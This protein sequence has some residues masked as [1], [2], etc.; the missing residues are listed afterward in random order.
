MAAYYPPPAGYYAPPQYPYYPPP[1]PGAAQPLPPAVTHHL[2]Q[3]Y[4]PFPSYATPAYPQVASYDE[5]RTLFIA[6][7]PEDVKPRE[8]YNLF[9]EFPGYESSHLR[10]PTEKTQP[11]G[12]AVFMDQQ[13][14]LAALHTLNG[15]VFDLEKGS[16]LHIDLAKSNSRSKR[17]RTDDDRHG[18]EKRSKGSSAFSRGIPDPVMDTLMLMQ[19]LQQIREI[20]QLPH[21]RHYLWLI[22]VQPVQSK[23]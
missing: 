4:Q 13:S 9:R 12:F 6:G 14:A 17:S 1:P 19:L 11:F 7:L 5:V 20:H 2:P 21:V 15:M 3:Q 22:W 23:S 16:T 18:S 10:N 8:I